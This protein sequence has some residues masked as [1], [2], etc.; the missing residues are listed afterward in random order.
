[1]PSPCKS[2]SWRRVLQSGLLVTE[3][4]GTV[5]LWN[6]TNFCPNSSVSHPRRLSSPDYML[7]VHC[8]EVPL[9]LVKA[10]MTTVDF[11]KSEFLT[12]MLVKASFFCDVKLY[13]SAPVYI[14]AGY[15]IRKD[16]NF[17]LAWLSLLLMERFLKI[18]RF[19]SAKPTEQ[20]TNQWGWRD[21]SNPSMEPAV[22]RG[23]KHRWLRALL[24]WYV[25]Q[26][27]VLCRS[28]FALNCISCCLR[29]YVHIA[30]VGNQRNSEKHNRVWKE[31]S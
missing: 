20:F 2:S 27:T 10:R 24:E 4:E 25:C 21:I 12:L 26:G 5:I 15:H 17:H 1:M 19:D 18:L 8:L 6:I 14:S 29:T 22:S 16:R 28:V 7:L 30:S 23:W 13:R 31:A 11:A 9:V 3:A